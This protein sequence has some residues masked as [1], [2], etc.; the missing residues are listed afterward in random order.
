MKANESLTY[1]IKSNLLTTKMYQP[2]P[3]IG[4]KQVD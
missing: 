3:Y 4:V 1:E 2:D